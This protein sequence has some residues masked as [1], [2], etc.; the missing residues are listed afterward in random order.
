MTDRNEL[1][2]ELREL[3]EEEFSALTDEGLNFAAR[4]LVWIEIWETATTANRF[5][6]GT[7]TL[8]NPND[9]PLPLQDLSVGQ[10]DRWIDGGLVPVGDAKIEVS[11]YGRTLAYLQGRDLE[12]NQ[13]MFF[14]IGGSEDEEPEERT[15]ELYTIIDS[16]IKDTGGITWVI[17][18]ERV[19]Q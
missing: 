6:A 10:V 1:L 2:D 5:K 15:G 8:T 18:L 12:D 4:E 13:T 19:A 14:R 7:R 11:Q 17:T 9:G 16:G 3:M